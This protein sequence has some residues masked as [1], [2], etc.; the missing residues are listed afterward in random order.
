MH[1]AGLVTAASQALANLTECN[2]L[3]HEGEK[4]RQKQMMKSARPEMKNRRNLILH[5]R[6][7]LI[8]AKKWMTK[9]EMEPKMR[10]EFAESNWL[11]GGD[12]MRG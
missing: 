5:H 4:T 2:I 1:L 8:E 10:E 7:W 12:C 11:P 6:R 9:M 3:Q